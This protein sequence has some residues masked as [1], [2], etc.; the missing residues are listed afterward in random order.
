MGGQRL[1]TLCTT[2]GAAQCVCLQGRSQADA[3][4]PGPLMQDRLCGCG[5]HAPTKAFRLPQTHHKGCCTPACHTSAARPLCCLCRTSVCAS[6]VCPPT[7]T[8]ARL[9]LLLLC[10]AVRVCVQQE[11][12]AGSTQAGAAPPSAAYQ[13]EQLEAQLVQLRGQLAQQEAAAANAGRRASEPA[14]TLVVAR[15][16]AAAP[17]PVP[18]PASADLAARGEA[19]AEALPAAAAAPDGAL[20]HPPLLSLSGAPFPTAPLF[21]DYHLPPSPKQSRGCAA[22]LGRQVQQQQQQQ[23]QQ[24]QQQEQLAQQQP[25]LAPEHAT[26]ATTTT[27]VKATPACAA[28]SNGTSSSSSAPPTP[29]PAAAAGHGAGSSGTTTT[30]ARSLEEVQARL[31]AAVRKG[32]RIEGE[33][34]AKDAEL[35]AARQRISKLEARTLPATAGLAQQQV[36]GQAA[37]ST[38]CAWL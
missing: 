9:W 38:D 23:Q 31:A 20:A 25:Q 37:P 1:R 5:T 17:A 16:G 22:A 14:A 34:K 32:K 18:A 15:T 26:T 7:H 3:G 21:K 6:P 2:Q 28:P 27:P 13:V 35:A 30:S 29:G 24:A 33:L 12:S 36:R 11:A 19:H 10:C 4:G 8:H